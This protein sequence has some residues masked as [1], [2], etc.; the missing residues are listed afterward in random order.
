[1]CSKETL[2]RTT[3]ESVDP[4]EATIR[5]DAAVAIPRGAAGGTTDPDATAAPVTATTDVAPV[6]TAVTAPAE[7]TRGAQAVTD[8][9]A[10]ATRANAVA[11]IADQAATAVRAAGSVVT[12]LAASS[13]AT[14][15]VEIVVDRTGAA[16]APSGAAVKAVSSPVRVT[17]EHSP[18][19][20]LPGPTSRNCPRTSSPVSSI[21][22][23]D[24]TC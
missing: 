13:V 16:V 15:P 20:A 10:A 9:R 14:G 4:T 19:D 2:W 3:T 7:A 11:T 6:A 8:D 22:L 1:L 23:S 18:N 5:N 24:A 17:E 21:R 12:V